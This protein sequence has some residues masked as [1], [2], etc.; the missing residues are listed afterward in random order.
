MGYVEL[1]ENF[2]LKT[3]IL[4]IISETQVQMEAKDHIWCEEA[5]AG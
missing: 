1:V 4:D 3:R 5:A 2:V